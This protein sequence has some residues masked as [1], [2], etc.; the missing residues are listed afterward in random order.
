M[1]RKYCVFTCSYN[2]LS[3]NRVTTLFILS[4]MCEYSCSHVYTHETVT[5][6]SILIR[7][8]S[9]THLYIYYIQLHYTL[10]SPQWYACMRLNLN[11]AGTLKPEVQLLRDKITQNTRARVCVCIYDMTT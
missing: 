8:R 2:H 6:L 9:H 3:T 7:A 10:T 1:A 5:T 11:P 4:R